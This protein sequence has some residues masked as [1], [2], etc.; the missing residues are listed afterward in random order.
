MCEG[1]EVGKSLAASH[2]RQM[3]LKQRQPGPDVIPK[4]LWC[5]WS[6]LSGEGA[7]TNFLGAL[8]RTAAGLASQR[9]F[10]GS[11]EDMAEIHRHLLV[12]NCVCLLLISRWLS[13]FSDLDSALQLWPGWPCGCGQALCS[14]I[15][16]YSAGS[17]LD[18]IPTAEVISGPCSAS[19]GEHSVGYAEL[20]RRTASLQGALSTWC[21]VGTQQAHVTART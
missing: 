16:I 17:E 13:W 12:P 18:V 14:G 1:P 4:T 15:F 2:R 11:V 8:W 5:Q 9:L 20:C 10:Q 19:C 7:W 6:I 21:C 3:W